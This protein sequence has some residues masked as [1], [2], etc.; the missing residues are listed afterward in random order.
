M[1]RCTSRSSQMVTKRRRLSW[2]F[3]GMGTLAHTITRRMTMKY[4]LTALL[5]FGLKTVLPILPVYGRCFVKCVSTHWNGLYESNQTC[6][7]YHHRNIRENNVIAAGYGFCVDLIF[8]EEVIWQ[9]K[10]IV[11]ALMTSSLPDV[12]FL[13]EGIDFV[14]LKKDI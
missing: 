2:T 5:E 6:W 13:L 9:Q 1:L 8:S 3:T 7:H 4:S 11:D 12:Q 10:H 14:R